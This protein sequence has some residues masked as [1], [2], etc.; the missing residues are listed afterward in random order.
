MTT[1]TEDSKGGRRGWLV[2][3][4]VLLGLGLAWWWHSGR[5]QAP[6]SD[7]AEGEVAAASAGQDGSTPR[8]VPPRRDDVDPWQAPR[9]AVAGTVRDEQGRPIAGAQ[10]CA[11]LQDDA[12]AQTTRRP[13][14]CSTTRDDG[15][16]RIEGLLAAE[17]HL[18]AAARGYLPARHRG[19]SG[20]QGRPDA[21]LG[22][23]AGTT[24][25][26]V[27]FVLRQGGVEL[28]GV[29]RD[30]SGG[31]IEGAWVSC[32]TEAWSEDG[33]GFARSDAEGRFSLWV[34]P[35][36]A[37]VSAF[38]DGYTK[39]SRTVAAPGTFVELFL[40]PESV[41]IGKV[42]WAEGGAPVA[43]ARVSVF[44]SGIAGRFGHSSGTVVSEEDG[45]FR[46][47]GLEPGGYKVS[48]VGEG[49]SGLAA[50]K[51]HVGLGQT[52]EPVIVEVHPAFSV[53]GTVMIGET[54][55]SRGGV[56]LED[57]TR[58]GEGYGSGEG[59]EDGT[60]R[61]QG[62]PPGT[63]EVTASCPGFL[64]EE[65]YPDVVV[66]DAS[67]E[68]LVWSVQAGAAVR[69]VV[70]DASGRPVEGATVSAQAKVTD[71]P[72]ARRLDVWGE[73]TEASGSFALEGLLGGSYDLTVYHRDLPAPH[74]PTTVE[75]PEG[76]VVE[77][78]TL[79][80]LASGEIHGIVRDEHGTGVAGASV[81]V[82]GPR[83]LEASTRDDG[84]FELQGVEVGEHRVT[85]QRGWSDTMRAPGATDDDAA[86]ERVS[87]RSGEV[88]EIELVVESQRGRITGRVLDEGGGPVADAFVEAVRESDSAAS[89]AGGSRA[90]ARWG[91]WTRQPVL[92]DDDGRFELTDLAEQ[93]VY[94]VLAN[95]KGGGE[96]FAEHV[97]AGSD[98]ELSIEPTGV[99]AGV[100]RLQ[101]GGF[102]ER[103]EI[104]ATSEAAGIWES[105][106]FSRTEGRWR[107]SGLPAGTYEVVVT[108]PEGNAKAEVELGQGAEKTDV[109]LVL[110]PRVRLRGTLVDAESGEPIAGLKV[111]VS[112]AGGGVTLS[113]GE[114]IK[115]NQKDVSDAQGRFEVDDAPTG[116]VYVIAMAPGFAKSDYGMAWLSRRVPAEPREQDLGRI[117]LVADRLPDGKEPGNLGFKVKEDEPDTQPEDSRKIVA[118]VDPKGP[119]ATAGLRVGDEI[120][121]VD[122]HDVRGEQSYRYGPLLRV[123]PGQ[124]VELG[125]VDG[126]DERTVTIVAGKPR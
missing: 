4:V 85:A 46:I 14:E 27:D 114:E 67:L 51:V 106:R 58:K 11:A 91:S 62:V 122:G 97:R 79:T 75:V 40:V 3:V 108:A 83:W 125:V 78:V 104:T 112:P 103:F 84:R 23:R 19:P 15:T 94:T 12:L 26:G 59:H 61:I 1:S 124:A 123:E 29:V 115:A 33:L 76:G 31:E 99:L 82:R 21:R 101:G 24:R 56:R 92:T 16:Y 126:E 45:R 77:G 88:A 90:E 57:R 100:V 66:T 30:L 28:T 38:A 69:G 37:H 39:S 80:M 96:A 89:S 118:V 25:E 9:A 93:G 119:A 18:H 111:S 13:P 44:D 72:R 48:A 63:Y 60:V 98:V 68:D 2:A 17:H 71:D 95:R 120:L 73:D 52:S 81:R 65:S 105:D 22:L 8:V 41:V 53:R 34:E 113:F 7:A 54:P 47:E 6:R 20:H 43:G 110:S 116:R 55:C 74:E 32:G 70:V 109:E 121:T 86:G 36:R 64:P 35:P 87:V 117:E 102:P 50:Q 107:L 42:V 10:V 5:P 49:L